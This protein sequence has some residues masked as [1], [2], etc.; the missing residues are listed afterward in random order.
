M[1]THSKTLRYCLAIAFGTLIVQMVATTWA[2]ADPMFFSSRGSIIY[3]FN[4]TDPPETFVMPDRFAAMSTDSAGNIWLAG[5][6]DPDEDTL[7]DL[8]TLDD[9]CGIPKLV[10]Q[11]SYLPRRL[12]SM[13]FIGDLM[14]VTYLDDNS[15]SHILAAVDVVNQT[16]TVVGDTGKVLAGIESSAFDPFTNILYG[17]N[18]GSFEGIE[19]QLHTIDWQ[20]LNGPDPVATIVGPTG[21]PSWTSGG[22]MYDG[23]YYHLVSYFVA[24]DSG[25]TIELGTINLNTGAFNTVRIVDSAVPTGTIGLA[26]LDIPEG[27]SC[28]TT[29]GCC[30]PGE[31]CAILSQATCEMYEGIYLGND[32]PCDN[33]ADG[34]GVVDCDDAC[35]DTE[36]GATVDQNGCS[37]EQIEDDE[38]PV[39]VFCLESFE[40]FTESCTY[41]LPDFTDDGK[42]PI[43]TDNSEPACFLEITQTPPAGTEI[44]P[45]E[46]EIQIKAT[47]AAGN[48]ATC[49]FTIT[50]LVDPCLCGTDEE[51]PVIEVCPEPVTL[52]AD[53]GCTALIPDLT[54]DVIATDNCLEPPTEANGDNENDNQGPSSVTLGVNPGLTITQDPPA[55]TSV[56]VGQT[57]VTI[58]VMDA[59]SNTATCE[60]TI[61]VEQGECV[62]ECDPDVTPPVIEGCPE[63]A[64]LNAGPGCT[65]TLGDLTDGV[66]ATDNCEIGKGE[67]GITITQ[68]PAAGTSLGVGTHEVSIIATDAAGNT[69][70]CIVN[71]TVNE[72]N[73]NCG[74]N[75]EQ[76]PVIETCASNRTLL[77]NANCEATVPDLTAEVVASDNCEGITIEQSPAAGTTIGVGNTVVTITVRD[78]NGNETTCEATLTVDENGCNDNG[79]DN[80]NDNDG[81]GPQPVPCDPNADDTINILFS[82]LFHAPVCGSGCPLMILA[83][84]CGFF[85]MRKGNRRTKR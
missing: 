51:P 46:T 59:N 67:S 75:D 50:V 85:V 19:P 7:L 68:D 64:E 42:G 3:R 22:D 13:T 78:A 4:L 9:P 60:V 71:V 32:I 55:G 15:T 66:T 69:S 44:G 52:Q 73:C 25:H 18:N 33:D 43:A 14:Y 56:G 41:T 63:T 82:L 40:T 28:P 61:T 16:V 83:T 80:D 12:S 47:D 35:P 57:V 74:E 72:N 70:S 53:T 36:E 2:V 76:P 27:S 58:T 26:I 20:L 29:G 6:R 45:G 5:R 38:P 21:R 49:T 65:A 77:A 23:T 54:G 1:T 10:H 62:N 30:F 79:N 24:A 37:C 11:G 17:I 8:Y 84:I 31:G 39:F 81:P 48:M 34:D